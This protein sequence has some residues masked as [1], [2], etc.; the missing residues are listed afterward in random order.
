MAADLFHLKLPGDRR[1]AAVAVRKAAI[2]GDIAGA[3]S[4][5]RARC[6]DLVKLAAQATSLGVWFNA[7]EAIR[8]GIPADEAREAVMSAAANKKGD[9]ND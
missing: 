1:R 6:A 7:A 2:A 5:D 3:L 9:Y 4:A 8:A